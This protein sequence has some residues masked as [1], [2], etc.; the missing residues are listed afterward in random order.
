MDEDE[1]NERRIKQNTQISIK[2]SIQIGAIKIESAEYLS[3]ND[4]LQFIIYLSSN[5][6]EDIDDNNELKQKKGVLDLIDLEV[7]KVPIF[8]I[9]EES[10]Y[11]TGR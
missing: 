10:C 8:L 3:S 2:E 5:D 1:W 4:I 6:E 7:T 11:E 9:T